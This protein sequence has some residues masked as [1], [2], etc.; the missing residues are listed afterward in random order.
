M[1]IFDGAGQQ[2]LEGVAQKRQRMMIVR[3]E[4][5]LLEDLAIL[6]LFDVRFESDQTVLARLLE[7]VVQNLQQLRLCLFVV[8][9]RFEQPENALDAPLHDAHRIAHQ[10]GTNR[11]A[12]DDD[13]FGPL[14]QHGDVPMVHRVAEQHASE[15]NDESNDDQHGNLGRGDELFAFGEE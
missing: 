5:V 10:E 11:G 8:R 7:H 4:R 15:D 13:E 2:H 9:I 3:E 12:A 6:R 14:E 1:V